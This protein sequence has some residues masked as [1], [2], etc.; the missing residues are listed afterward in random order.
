MA[1]CLVNTRS[2]YNNELHLLLWMN[3]QASCINKVSN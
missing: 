2:R 1:M 3:A